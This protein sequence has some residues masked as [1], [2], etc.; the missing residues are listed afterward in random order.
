EW[1]GP[2]CGP[3]GGGGV[4]VEPGAPDRRSCVTLPRHEHRLADPQRATAACV[5]DDREPDFHPWALALPAWAIE[6]ASHHHDIHHSSNGW[7]CGANARPSP[8]MSTAPPPRGSVESACRFEDKC[9]PE[10]A[11][12]WGHEQMHGAAP[13]VSSPAHR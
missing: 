6:I 10:L 5:E 3:R 13:S 11:Y 4:G 12:T 8:R 1:P 7:K 9:L 2:P